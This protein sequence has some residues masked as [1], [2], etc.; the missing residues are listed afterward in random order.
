MLR[1]RS[2]SGGAGELFARDGGYG[3]NLPSHATS[4]AALV[5][6][7]RNTLIFDDGDSLNLTLGARD[8]WWRRGRVRG[9]PTRWGLLDLDFRRG[10][11]S[12]EWR[13]TPVPVWTA[14]TLPPGMRLDGPP[15]APLIAA[16]S[17]TALLAPP[18]TRRARA[19]IRSGDG[20]L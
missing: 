17:G 7:V 9:A 4:A 14:L 18:G 13:W 1:W 8:A 12:A 2:A 16:S 5:S 10:E 6:L 15:D 3:R 20:S 19:R 11:H